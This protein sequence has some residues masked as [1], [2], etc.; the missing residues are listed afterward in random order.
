LTKIKPLTCEVAYQRTR[1]LLGK[2]PPS[3]A[4]EDGGFVQLALNRQLQ[5]LIVWHAGP[6]KE[7]QPRG[8]LR[9]T[10]SVRRPGRNAG[11]RWLEAQHEFGI[12]ENAAQSHLDPAVEA[13]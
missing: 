12:G 6:E 7:R 13:P 2:H 11:R 3:L 8:Q 5:Q 4:L 9:V 10:D 1:R